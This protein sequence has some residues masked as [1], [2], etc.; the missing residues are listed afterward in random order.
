[1]I[2]CANPRMLSEMRGTRLVGQ[3]TKWDFTIFGFPAGFMD[4]HLGLK[5]KTF[6]GAFFL[7]S[8][9]D[10]YVHGLFIDIVAHNVPC[11]DKDCKHPAKYMRFDDGNGWYAA[12]PD[13]EMYH[14]ELL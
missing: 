9:E 12:S 11:E 13:V 14:S 6:H 5:R 10:S 8:R 2:I 7:S 4:W 3:D 1:M